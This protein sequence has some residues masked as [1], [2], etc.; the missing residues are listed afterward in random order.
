MSVINI[1][2][3]KRDYIKHYNGIY[4]YYNFISLFL[5]LSTLYKKKYIAIQ[6]V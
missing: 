2:T 4:L 6:G 1:K 5:I 3:I